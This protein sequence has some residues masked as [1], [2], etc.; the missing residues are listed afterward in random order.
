[1]ETKRPG[2]WLYGFVLVSAPFYILLAYFLERHQSGYLIT[3]Y[4]VLFLAYLGV[5]FYSSHFR[6][7]DLVMVSVL[8]RGLLFFSFPNLS[9][10]IYRFVW[11]GRLIQAGIHPFAHLPSYF[12]ETGPLPGTVNMELY[13]KLNSPDYYTIYPPI[14]QLIFWLSTLVSNSVYGSVIFIR[15]CILMAELGTIWIL[16]KL[17]KTYT[18]PSTGVF[19][20]ALNPLVILELTGNLHF[21]AFMIFFVLLAIYYYEKRKLHLSAMGFGFGIAVKLLPLMFMP[22]LIRRIPFKKLAVFFAIVGGVILVLFFPLVDLSLWRGMGSSISLYFQKFEFNASIYYIVREVG[23]WVKGYNIIGSAGRWLSVITFLGIMALSL[24]S[25]PR[26]HLP[27]V[28]LWV[29][30]LY[31]FM[32]TTVHP[33]YITTLVAFSALGGA[34]FPIV[35]SGLIFLTYVGYTQTSYQESMLLV[36]LEYTTVFAFVGYELYKMFNTRSLIQQ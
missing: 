31:L 11:D 19:F 35:W 30:S 8:F 15:S 14:A 33:W 17:T 4:A 6:I 7:K 27:K 9:D 5:S 36:I 3:G 34:K 32:A 26:V 16:L 18:L 28:L 29:L 25:K 21:E 20:Y 12:V 24:V 22:V 1:M 13:Q 10:D 2:R 23:Y